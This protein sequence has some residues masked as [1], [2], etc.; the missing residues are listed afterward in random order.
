MK[1]NR[2]KQ[3]PNVVIYGVLYAVIFDVS[4]WVLAFHEDSPNKWILYV[5]MIVMGLNG[6]G[7]T[8]ISLAQDA[9]TVRIK[10]ASAILKEV[11][12]DPIVDPEFFVFE[13]ST[14]TVVKGKRSRSVIE[15]VSPP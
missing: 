1:M 9:P 4:I 5:A 14:R 8:C 15:T 13:G 6:L 12:I 10:L 11:R 2:N 3:V 7:K